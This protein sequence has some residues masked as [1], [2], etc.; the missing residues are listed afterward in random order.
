METMQN[1]G[2][3][4]IEITILLVI[5]GM[6]MS[7]FIQMSRTY[8]QQRVLYDTYDRLQK[9]DESLSAGDSYPCPAN[10]ALPF[11]DAKSGV[12][13]CAAALRVTGAGGNDVLIGAV[14]YR[15]LKERRT[16]YL[17]GKPVLDNNG[18]PVSTSSFNKDV[19]GIE[20]VDSWGNQF[21]YAVTEQLTNNTNFDAPGAIAV[22]T[23]NAGQ[24]LVQPPGSARFVIFSPGRDGM[25]GYNSAG[26]LRAPCKPAG[27][28]AD[29]E[30]CDSDAIFISALRNEKPGAAHYDDVLRFR[31]ASFQGLWNTAAA[32]QNL[33]PG[34]VGIGL[35]AAQQPIVKLDLGT[36]TAALSVRG[37]GA[38]EDGHVRARAY[39]T[40]D[41]A[42]FVSAGPSPNCFWPELLGANCVP[43][44]PANSVSLLYG[45]RNGQILCRDV[46]LK[47]PVAFTCPAGQLANGFLADGSVSCATP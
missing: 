38:S 27:T 26:R 31:R 2:L 43:A 39:C 18:N 6:G 29:A 30:N 36:G 45:I 37:G 9:I 1:R 22:R 42:G 3:T 15:T 44:D 19:A 25:G 32:V 46:P 13:D 24:S 33:N 11:S 17:Y 8:L 34:N 16:L 20:A 14:P 21:M 5:M 40:T 41:E 10:P 28:A 12:E 47:T 4:F 7:F 35:A 23:E